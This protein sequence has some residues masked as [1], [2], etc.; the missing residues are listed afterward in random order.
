[1][2]RIGKHPPQ[3]AGCVENGLEGLSGG[4]GPDL[5]P[6]GSP[7]QDQLRPDFGLP[8]P[9]TEGLPSLA[10]NGTRLRLTLR[11]G[12]DCVAIQLG[13]LVLP[14]EKSVETAVFVRKEF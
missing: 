14:G 2:L 5:I 3:P 4:R 12:A 6:A 10:S 1:M 8:G 7:R 13:A 9:S 11:V